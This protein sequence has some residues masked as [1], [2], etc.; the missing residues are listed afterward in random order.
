[1]IKLLP[2]N[3]II[4]LRTLGGRKMSRK[5][6]LLISI[7]AICAI[8][9]LVYTGCARQAPT[10]QTVEDPVETPTDTVDEPAEPAE[11]PAA[12]EEPAE[13]PLNI[14]V[15]AVTTGAFAQLG[16]DSID[17]VNLALEEVDFTIA[18]REVKLHIGGTD[19]SPE[20]AIDQM[21][22]LV[23]RDNCQLVLGPLSGSEGIAVKNSASEWP[24]T[25]V[26]VAAS[27]GEDV[28][29]RGIEPNVWRT[30]FNGAQPMFPF[31]KYV[32]DQGYSRVVTIG[33]D[34]DY[35]YAQVAGFLDTFVGSG[36]EVAKKYWVPIGTADYS[37]VI[38]DMPRDIDAI[39]VTLS[40][41]DVISFLEQLEGFG[42][43]YPVVGGTVGL[44][45][46]TVT[47]LGE[48]LEGVVSG[49]I[50]TG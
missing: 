7:I 49:S 5:T 2:K 28:T 30:S 4:I 26:I 15:L 36:G 45:A 50:W 24:D 8:M 44:D 6:F 10:P 25:T 18:G 19:I 11:E 47:T 43:D 22:A 46:G 21:R 33:E 31:G 14:G 27:A 16:Q 3:T 42:L 1:V 48:S 23:T 12:V 20:S 38:A 13:G 17:G 40:G 9:V 39:Y 37:S 35:P 34:Y 29:M 41:T 32:Y